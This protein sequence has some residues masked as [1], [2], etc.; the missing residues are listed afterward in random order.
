MRV[1]MYQSTK[2]YYVRENKNDEPYGPLNWRAADKQA[3]MLSRDPKRSGLAEMLT[4]VGNRHL[5]P[6]QPPRYEV[7]YMYIR[8]VRVLGGSLAQYHSDNQLPPVR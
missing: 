3:R 2:E 1:P 8:G 5:D 6:P 7:M 4:I